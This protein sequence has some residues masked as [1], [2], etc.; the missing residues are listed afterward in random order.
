MGWA[1]L[2]MLLVARGRTVTLG[3]LVR[4]GVGTWAPR[5]MTPR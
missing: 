2:A 5:P 3:V 1:V 4:T